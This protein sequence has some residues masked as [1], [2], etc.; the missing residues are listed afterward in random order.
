MDILIQQEASH[1]HQS[2]SR[3]QVC[4]LR[5]Q[6]AARLASMEC[7][8]SGLQCLAEGNKPTSRSRGRNATAPRKAGCQVLVPE[9]SQ[10]AAYANAGL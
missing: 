5:S 9:G 6:T 10:T 3:K 4:R 8:S 2:P 7:P 1:R